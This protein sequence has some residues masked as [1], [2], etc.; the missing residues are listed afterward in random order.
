M[1]Y[2]LAVVPDSD[3]PHE[4]LEKTLFAYW[5]ISASH[6][7]L[8]A[9]HMTHDFTRNSD[10]KARRASSSLAIRARIGRCAMPTA[11]RRLT[12]WQV[13]K[14]GETARN[15]AN[16]LCINAIRLHVATTSSS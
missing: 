3:Q 6:S 16:L 1:I 4:R 13:Q 11:S 14:P 7:M 9:D 12:T 2:D 5:H 15:Q 10:V 8:A